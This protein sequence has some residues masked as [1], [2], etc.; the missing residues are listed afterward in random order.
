MEEADEERAEY[1]LYQ[2]ADI[3]HLSP[4]LRVID[5]KFESDNNALFDKGVTN[6]KDA[7]KR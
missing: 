2:T 7:L 6:A 4:K 3:L 1:P 5:K